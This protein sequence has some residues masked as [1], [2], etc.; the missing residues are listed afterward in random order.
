MSIENMEWTGYFPGVIGKIT[1][2]H[3]VYYHK[4]WGFDRRF[5]A[6]VGREVSE[7]ISNFKDP[8][9][10][11]RAV[12]TDGSF[13]GCCAVDGHLAETEGARLRWFIVSPAVHGRGIGSTLIEDA[14]TF[15]RDTGYHR[16]FLWTFAGLTAAR[17]LYETAG[18][19]KC[20][21]HPVVQW[22][23]EIV[24]QQFEIRF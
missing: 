3:A 16:L 21:E 11:L 9:D 7:F 14:V 1:E 20:A 5:E 22:G 17:R 10:R 6:Q 24:E 12:R 4:H 15:C 13:A 8:Q 2:L 18:F 23:Q 19:S